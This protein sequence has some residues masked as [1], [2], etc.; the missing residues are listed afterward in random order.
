MICDSAPNETGEN[1]EE[2]VIK[3]FCFQ[4][5]FPNQLLSNDTVDDIVGFSQIV[6]GVEIFKNIFS[7]ENKIL[8]KNPVKN[9][10]ASRIHK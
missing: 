10:P 3:Q 1:A 8:E 4:Y 2:N 7:M 9:T 6:N 5:L